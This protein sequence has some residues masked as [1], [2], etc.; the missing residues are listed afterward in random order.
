MSQYPKGIYALIIRIEEPRELKIG[1]LV[2]DEFQGDYLY[3]GSAHGPG[4]LQRVSRHLKAAAGESGNDHW[5]IDY[6]I[7][8]G[9]I[10]ETWL[11]PTDK[12]LECELATSLEKSFEQPVKDFG[13][14]DCDCFSHLFNYDSEQKVELIKKL[15]RIEPDCKPIR[16][17]WE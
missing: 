14:S 3:V 15:D 1:D 7:G 5:H 2:R 13:S 6:L 9:V 12:D 8:P 16:F 17:D 4:G 11:L 10:R